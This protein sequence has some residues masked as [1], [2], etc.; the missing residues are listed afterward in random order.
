MSAFSTRYARALA[1][2]IDEHK[3][4]PSSSLHQ[5]KDF[6]M[7]LS[8][9]RDLREAM[10]NPAIP[11]ERRVSVLDAINRKM[12]AAPE[13]RNFLAVLIHHGRLSALDE[14]IQSIRQEFNRR[15][16]IAAVDIVSAR[17]LAPS[18][19]AELETRAKGLAGTEVKVTF[20]EDS[21]LMG[22]AIIQIGST[23]YDG[24]LRGRLERLREQL[25]AG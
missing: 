2:I 18:Q 19:R 25:A 10:M 4:D 12:G 3:I 13:I 5:L 1:D 17:E 8:R 22:G 23:V 15:A 6:S 14:I 20:R 9:S 7:I 11:V 21:S 16:S 24:S